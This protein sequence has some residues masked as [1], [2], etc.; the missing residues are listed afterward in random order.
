MIFYYSNKNVYQIYDYGRFVHGIQ[1]CGKVVNISFFEILHFEFARWNSVVRECYLNEEKKTMASKHP[2]TKNK[3]EDSYLI[4]FLYSSYFRPEWAITNPAKAQEKPNNTRIIKYIDRIL[5]SVC[6]CACVCLCMWR[7]HS[8]ECSRFEIQ[9]FSGQY[10]TTQYP[11]T[12]H[13]NKACDSLFK[14]VG[15]LEIICYAIKQNH[16]VFT[17]YLRKVCEP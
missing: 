15:W 3:D 9:G 17:I 7:A 4:A 13:C 8:R 16:F 5:A 14:Y 12:K 10:H 6:V 11:N 2:L 1:F